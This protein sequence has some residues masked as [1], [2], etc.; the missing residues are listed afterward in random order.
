[1]NIIKNFTAFLKEVNA[2]LK[3]V[4]WSSRDEIIGSTSVVIITVA[5]L[6]VF[7]GIVDFILARIITTL[8]R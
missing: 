7:I 6:S 4:S 3:K 2:E 1:M 5:L 8:V